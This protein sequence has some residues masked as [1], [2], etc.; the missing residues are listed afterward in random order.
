MADTA[1][2]KEHGLA[3][4]TKLAQDDHFR[5]HFEQ[6]PAEALHKLGVPAE[7]I[8]GLP[9]LCLCPRKL[10]SKQAMEQARARLAGNADNSALN[11]VV[12]DAKF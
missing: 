4:L 3:L 2:T 6:K 9:A 5:A 8:V 12:P 10:G 1:L 11:F 7:T